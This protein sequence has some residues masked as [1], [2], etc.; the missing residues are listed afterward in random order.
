MTRPDPSFRRL[1]EMFQHE[2][3]DEVAEAGEIVATRL[4]ADPEHAALAPVPVMMAGWARA[5]QG[6][7]P[8]GIELIE[9]GLR[10][11]ADP[12]AKRELG[13]VDGFYLKL[14]EL[15]LLTGANTAAREQLAAMESLDA[16][17]EVRFATQRFL[18]SMAVAAGDDTR[19]AALL[20]V[21]ESIAPKVPGKDAPLLVAG[22]R[23][24][25]LAATG[26]PGAASTVAEPVV[27]RFRS[28]RH[29]DR[30]WRSGH[31]VA[32]AA[33]IAA[34]AAELGDSSLTRIWLTRGDDALEHTTGGSAQRGTAEL[35]LARAALARSD[36]DIE[37]AE[38]ASRAALE[39]FSRMGMRPAAAAARLQLAEVAVAKR[40]GAST[41]PALR[42]VHAQ[43]VELEQHRLAAAAERV[44]A[45]GLARVR[46]PE[47]TEADRVRGVQQLV[48]SSG[49]SSSIR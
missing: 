25:W 6:Y 35:A 42:S 18:A 34:S 43:L 31:V 19:A 16:P 44:R 41:E 10:H 2:R 12:N 24:I 37:A 30:A 7:L 48:P 38:I 49:T 39:T 17:V 45:G 27:D 13:D 28:R 9:R 22:D 40:H 3:W 29:R 5:E 20:G 26:Q 15:Y 36:G 4:L 14:V 46:E 32:V 23:A 8:T 47:A 33:A 21:A 1:V 11:L